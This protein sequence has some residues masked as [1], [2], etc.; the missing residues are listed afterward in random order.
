MKY[1]Y[2]HSATDQHLICCE[3]HEIVVVELP[4]IKPINT[5]GERVKENER[6]AIERYEKHL[7]NGRL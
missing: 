7:S 5:F 6:K 1:T 4:P 3:T 2:I